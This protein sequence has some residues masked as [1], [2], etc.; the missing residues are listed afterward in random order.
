MSTKADRQKAVGDGM[1]KGIREARKAVETFP[2][3]SP[4]WANVGLAGNSQKWTKTNLE[5]T[6]VA[7]ET[8]RPG[9]L[10]TL[11]AKLVE[12]TDRCKR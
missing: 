6:D 5:A 7:N 1:V 9:E 11:V 8:N 2:E 4:D 10:D 12:A 3:S